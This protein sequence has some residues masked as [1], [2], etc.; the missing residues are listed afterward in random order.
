MAD[1]DDNDGK[2]RHFNMNEIVKSEKLKKKGKKAR[3]NATQ[4]IVEDDFTINTAD[5]RF[6]KLYESHEFAI[7]PTNP[8]FKDTA[9]MKALLEE[10][11]KKRK[12]GKDGEEH[13][14]ERGSKKVRQDGGGAV[15]ED[16]QKLAARVKAKSGGK[17]KGSA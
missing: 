1:E 17:Q 5:P 2:M 4:P 9:A 12:M 8:R 13:E 6:A 14:V 11:R 3:K 10:G 16:V 7:D 15:E